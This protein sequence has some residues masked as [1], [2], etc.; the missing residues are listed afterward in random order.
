[1]HPARRVVQILSTNS[2]EG[3]SLAPDARSRTGV[4][5]LDEG[6]KDPGMGIG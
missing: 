3:E 6:G 5:A 2:V 1:M 4:H